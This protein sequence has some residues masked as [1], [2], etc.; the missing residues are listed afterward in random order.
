[1][2][3]PLP[4]SPQAPRDTMSLAPVVPPPSA[5]RGFHFD[6]FSE[7]R[8]S[9]IVGCGDN[10]LPVASRDRHTILANLGHASQVRAGSHSL[11]PTFGEYPQI[12]L[13]KCHRITTCFLLSRTPR[14]PDPQVRL[15]RS[16]CPDRYRSDDAKTSH[17]SD[18]AH[19]LS[20]YRRPAAR[21]DYVDTPPNLL[22]GIT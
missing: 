2:S 9:A 3:C 13:Q 12:P 18:L 6:H 20:R 16:L 19:R 5:D 14:S 17:C 10:I 4:Q 22:G 11:G 7:V 15:G 21:P 8:G 1:M